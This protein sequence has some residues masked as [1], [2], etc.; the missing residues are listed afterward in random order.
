MKTLIVDDCEI[1]RATLSRHL[2]AWG[3]EPILAVD[4]REAIEI[5]AE[6][7]APRLLIVDWMMPEMTGPE[8]IRSLREQDPDR[9]SYVIM[10]TAKTSADDLDMAFKCGADDFLPKP[11]V[12][13]NLYRSIRE[14]QNILER[15]DLV[16]NALDRLGQTSSTS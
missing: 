2:K 10:L 7:D 1:V 6:V 9:S 12:E 8:L 16:I 4:G 14:G 5:L 11:I 15:Q 13:A 3:L